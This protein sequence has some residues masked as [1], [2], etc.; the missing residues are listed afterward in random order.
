[1]AGKVRTRTNKAIT[2][3]DEFVK[4]NLVDYVVFALP[5]DE[6]DALE[7]ELQDRLDCETINFNDDGELEEESLG[8]DSLAILLQTLFDFSIEKKRFTAEVSISVN[9]YT[10]EHAERLVDDL[11]SGLDCEEAGIERVTED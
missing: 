1:M 4:I 11:L 2:S 10:E 7:E 8:F 3:L 5:K 6:I 9:A